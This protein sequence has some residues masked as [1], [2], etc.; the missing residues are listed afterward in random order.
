M[1]ARRPPWLAELLWVLGTAFVAMLAAVVDLRLWDASLHIPFANAPAGD[2]TFFLASVKG[3]VEHGWFIHNPDLAAPLG[4]TN[5]DFAASFGDTGHYVIIK[6]LALFVGNPVVVFNLFYLLAFPLIAITAFLVLRDLGSARLPALVAAVLFAVLP[7]HQLRQEAHLFL[8]AYYGIPLGVWLTVALAEGRTLLAR[9]DRRRTA[10]TLAA[11]IV[12]ASASNYYAVFAVLTLLLVV[13]VAALAQRSRAIAVQGLLVVVAIGFVF[14]L[15]HAPTVIY[16]A[17]HGRNTA[18][19]ERSPAESEVFGLKLTQLVLPRPEHRIAAFARRGAV[20]ER[21]TP[22]V[23]EGFSPSLGVVATLG[24]IG[25][26]V[27]L[28]AT[29]L[30]PAAVSLRRQRMSIAGAVALVCFAIGTVS[31]I[32]ALI[33][34]ELTPQVRGWNRISLLIAFAALL[35]VALALTA[36]GE[37]WRTRGRPAW[38]VGLIVVAIGVLGYLDQTSPH[39]VPAY[40]ANAAI[41]NNDETFVHG[42]E[43][44]LPRGTSVLQLPYIPYPENGPVLGMSDY[45]HFKPYVHSHHLRWSYGVTKGRPDDWED[46]A[47]VFAPQELAM[48]ATT[49]GFGAVYINRAGLADRGAA[50]DA[51]LTKLTGAGPAGSSSDGGQ[52][53]YDLRPFAARL[54]RTTTPSERHVLR[55][56]L[57]RP[58]D[59]SYGAGFSFQEADAGGQFRWA[60]ADALLTVANPQPVNRRIR[61]VATIFGGGPQP[62]T[63]QVGLPDG[64]HRTL[65]TSDKGAPLDLTF[66]VVP[67]R[68]ELHLQTFGPQAPSAPN[69]VRD[70]HLR[71]VSLSLRDEQVEPRLLAT[72]IA[73]ANKNAS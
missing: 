23:S 32:S 2:S 54:A 10:I 28:L 65:T 22:L 11:C 38:V 60:A 69:N 49:A 66:V 8:V 56:A 16:A 73:A 40:A 34:F 26:V 45:D 33:A 18:I 50:I 1:L 63:V 19:A 35:V 72:L 43:Q 3:V 61:L 58:A 46:D 30:G 48:L 12:V 7:Y 13:P 68:N 36:A 44:R 14:G 25:A 57:I 24:L 15:C 31:G 67:G 29:G 20:Y 59:I 53:Y 64:T 42:M 51:G 6:A 55:D 17:Q 41:W 70:Q 4:Q 62:S 5:L 52:A 27:A 37:R 47:R 21:Q 71:V 9:A 39:D